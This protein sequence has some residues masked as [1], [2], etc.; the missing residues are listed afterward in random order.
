MC[1]PRRSRWITYVLPHDPT[2]SDSV[3][4]GRVGS[5][6]FDRI[7]RDRIWSQTVAWDHTCFIAWS[8][9]I[10]S[11]PRRSRGITR[12]FPHDTTRWDH[13]DLVLGG[14]V[15]SIVF[16]RMIPRDGIWP[17]A[18]AWDHTCF[19]AWWNAIGSDPRRSRGITRVWQHDPTRSDLAKSDRVG[20]HVFFRMIPRDRIWPPTVAWD[21]TFFTAW[22]HAIGFGPWWSRGI[23]CVLPYDP[24]RSD[25]VLGGRVGS[26]VFYLI[27]PR[28][29]IWS[30]TV[31]WDQTC[32]S[33]WSH[34]IVYCTRRT[35]GITCVFLYDPTRSDLAPDDRVGSHAFLPHDPT[36]SHLAKSGRVRSPVVCDIIPRDR[37]WANPVAWDH[38]RLDLATDGRVGSH[39]F[40]SMIPRDRIWSR[41]VAWDHTC[42]VARSHTNILCSSRG[43]NVL[44]SCIIFV[45]AECKF[46][47]KFE[48]IICC[49]CFLT[50]SVSPLSSRCDKKS[51]ACFGQAQRQRCAIRCMRVPINFNSV[52]GSW[53]LRWSEMEKNLDMRKSKSL[54]IFKR[55]MVQVAPTLPSKSCK[56]AASFASTVPEENKNQKFDSKCD[57]NEKT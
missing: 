34:A 7:P 46:K 48:N 22:S 17:R 31:A 50:T 44:T 49:M 37:I 45:C 14:R 42:F 30:Q 3:P 5:H 36:R 52:A 55:P 26:H 41:T 11:G 23:T 47:T 9:S 57:Q 40:Y 21:D 18:V 15:G 2:R 32:C 16:Y 1:D 39:V 38:T 6:V 12:V 10:G 54:T 53:E 27:I 51:A 20:S 43:I 56:I 4:D 35:R 29:R 8:N 24:T 13:A 25:V 28:D 19:T 33:A